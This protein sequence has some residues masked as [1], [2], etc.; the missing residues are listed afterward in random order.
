MQPRFILACVLVGLAA[1]MPQ[2]FGNGDEGFGGFVPASQGF[3][4]F[5]EDFGPAS[6]GFQDFEEDFGPAS[7]GFQD[8]EDFGPASQGFQDSQDFGTGCEFP[9]CLRAG[10][11]S[12]IIGANGC[13]ICPPGCEA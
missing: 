13:F 10:D 11:C 4:D 1:A 8:F 5:E 12:A 7:Q 9:I 3:Q 6:Q 2:A